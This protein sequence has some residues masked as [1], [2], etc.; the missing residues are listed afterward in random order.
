MVPPSGGLRK[1][2][3]ANNISAEADNLPDCVL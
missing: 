2:Q 1:T 3:A